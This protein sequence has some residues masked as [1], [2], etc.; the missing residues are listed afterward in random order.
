MKKLFLFCCVLSLICPLADIS[1][2]KVEGC[3]IGVASGKA[4]ADGRP[5]LWKNANGVDGDREVVYFKDGRFKYLAVAAAGD[6]SWVTAGVNEFG[7]C[8]NYSLAFNLPDE[9]K[10]GMGGGGMTKLAL[11]QCVTVDD[12][13]RLLNQTNISGRRTTANF[14]VIDAFGGAAIFE[15]GNFSYTRFDANDPKVA[16]QGYIVR[17]NFA[18]TG[19]DDSRRTRQKFDRA[20]Q[21]W[22]QAIEKNQ[23]DYRYILRKVCRDLSGAEKIS[24]TPPRTEV[25][26]DNTF[27]VLNTKN[28]ISNSNTMWVALFHGVGPDENPSLTTFWAIMGEPTFSVG[29][30][31]WVIAESTAPEMDGAE[32]SP[33]CTAARDLHQANYL[34]GNGRRL[35]LNPDMLP[36]IW[37]L[38]YPAE[39]RIFDQTENILTQWRQDYPT[40]Q[41]VASFHQHMASDAMDAL[42][43]VIELLVQK[44]GTTANLRV[45]LYMRDLEKAKAF[46]NEGFNINVLDG[47]G[48][49]PLHYAVQNNQEK[50][51]ELLIS[52]NADVNAKNWSGQTP[53]DI[54]VS[55]NHKEIVELL[56]TKGADIS[57]HSA[58][59]LGDLAIVKSLIEKEVDI[60]AKDAS[61]R[62]ALHHA[63]EKGRKDVVELLIAKGADVNAE[64]N[65]GNTP[66]HVALG[67]K[68]R[69][70][71]ELLI[72]K[73]VNLASIHLSAYQGDLDKVKSFIEKGIGVNAMDSYGATPLHYA[74]KRGSKEV[75]E[76]LI[77]KG[78]DVNAK[79]KNT[80]T[81]LHSAT[82]GESK[83]IV[84]LLI[85]NGAEI[86]V[87][88][89]WDYTPIY[90]AVWSGITE[91]VEL[92]VEEGADLN[93]K[94]QWGWTPLH[95]VAAGGNV[96]MVELLIV[97]GADVNAKNNGGRTPLQVAKEKGHI[98][99][100]E[101]LR[102]HRAKEDKVP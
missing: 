56:I 61:G 93:V 75:V 10:K 21:L 22:Q 17:T 86:N 27:D 102:K 80:N 35:L 97:K 15:T 6:P 89:Q 82:G 95:E 33:L 19:G 68:N 28:A 78:A 87:K 66:G 59:R 11:Q 84:K 44:G 12:F 30:P 96:D 88:G 43:E 18:F 42:Q 31:S 81:P 23:L 70:I 13:E 16:P 60:N 5:L 90:A 14:G 94:D 38:T 26:E 55:R 74:A 65:S 101:L 57:L 32:L 20:N 49:A 100:V 91:I 69:P 92:L 79:D 58:S 54:A 53:V 83:D 73:G 29:V 41:Q 52:E 9:S 40:A 3:T 51:I 39:D 8:I 47:H 64:D 72:V 77:A 45:A 71:L 85:N 62:T 4:T 25:T 37:A 99:I 36:D 24:Y 2:E 50:I 48:Y 46:I 7:F 67:E 76:L 1:Q 98:K 34:M 63:V